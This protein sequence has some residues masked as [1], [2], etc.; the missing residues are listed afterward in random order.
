MKDPQ[1]AEQQQ[2]QRVCLI[3]MEVIDPIFSGNG[4]A[5]RSYSRGILSRPSTSL[6]VLCAQPTKATS[7]D[8][9]QCVDAEVAKAL[10]GTGG[11]SNEIQG[12]LKGVAI[13]VSKWGVTDRGSAWEEYGEGMS[14]A[15]VREAV[16]AFNPTVFVCVDWTGSQALEVLRAHAFTPLSSPRIP[17]VFAGFCMFHALYSL[18]PDDAAFYRNAEA[19]AMASASLSTVL[20]EIDK[21]SLAQLNPALPPPTVLLPPLRHDIASLV[22]PGSARRGW[23]AEEEGRRRYVTC[24]IRVTE[25]KNVLVFCQAVGLLSDLLRGRGLVPLLCGAGLKPTHP[26]APL[27]PYARHCKEVLL[28][29]CPWAEI[30]EEFLS[31]P[32]LLEKLSL[33]AIN[34]HPA[35]YEAYG[36]TI[37]EAAAAGTP[38][39]LHSDFKSIGAAQLLP[40]PG[41]PLLGS[42]GRGPGSLAGD[43]TDAAALAAALAHALDDFPALQRTA[44]VAQERAVEWGEDAF[45]AAFSSLLLSLPSPLSPPPALSQT[46][47]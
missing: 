29:K 9:A 40:P 36:M 31:P 15:L 20:S 42:D 5:S 44:V 11:A 3:S 47:S 10:F 41:S 24:C 18:S 26:G 37:V 1:F 4:V 46:L 39:L 13:A 28:A 38:T 21:T 33:S 8:P 30:H 12:R 7:V 45:G 35:P 19:R 25:A 43:S 23:G 16:T 14:C 2:G 6:L 22:S 27:A 32:E 34:V 17:E